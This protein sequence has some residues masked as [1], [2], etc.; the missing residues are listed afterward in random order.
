LYISLLF[1][2]FMAIW[3]ISRPFSIFCGYLV[4]FE[5]IWYIFSFL[6]HEESGNPGEVV[7]RFLSVHEKS[8]FLINLSG[9]SM[10]AISTFLNYKL[11]TRRTATWGRFDCFYTSQSTN[12]FHR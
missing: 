7:K 11:L 9:Q 5:S 3:Y 6:H 1:L 12:P 8:N 10:P 4:Y 2:T